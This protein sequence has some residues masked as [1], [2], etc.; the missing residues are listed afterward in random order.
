MLK[1][2]NLE[3]FGII[4]GI[5]NKLNG[6]WYIGQTKKYYGFKGRYPRA[7]VGVE[8]VYKCHKYSKDRNN[9][10][11]EHLLCSIEKYGFKAFEV[12]EVL[13]YAFSEKELNIKEKSWVLIKD[14][15]KNAYN[16]NE[17]GDSGLYTIK[18][19]DEQIK[20]VKEM[21]SDINNTP[22]EIEKETGV[23]R[24]YIYQIMRLETRS[25]IASELND[26]ILKI[27]SIHYTDIFMKENEE[28][29]ADM[30][31]NG[32]SEE[33][34]INS[35][36]NSVMTPTIKKKINRFLWILKYRKLGQTKIC[37]V[38]GEEFVIK[39][40]KALSRKY[41]RKCREKGYKIKAK[42]YDKKKNPNKKSKEEKIK[43]KEE[44]LKQIKKEVLRLYL[45]EDMK[46]TNIFKIYQKHGIVPNDIK[47]ILIEEGVFKGKYK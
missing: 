34:I 37:S 9:D 24:L 30:Y 17:G 47:N 40:K 10:Y 19:N 41:C 8:R 20:L 31:Y 14:S 18:Y 38:C 28:Y 39:N 13:D 36:D 27:R 23:P 45:E 1:V 29:I 5:E 42:E 15:F 16:R 26:K 22:Y 3:V 43:I 33:D 35:F 32:Y 44:Y 12:H 7:G 4:Y 21:L 25:D 11:N 6:K 2:G 46:F